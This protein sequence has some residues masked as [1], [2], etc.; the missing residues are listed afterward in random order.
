MTAVAADTD[1]IFRWNITMCYLTNL[2]CF[3]WDILTPN[4]FF[5]IWITPTRLLYLG[6]GNGN[7]HDLNHVCLCQKVQVLKIRPDELL[8]E[9]YK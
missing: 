7:N 1:W 3:L 6:L 4:N 9:N 2:G 8:I 5:Q